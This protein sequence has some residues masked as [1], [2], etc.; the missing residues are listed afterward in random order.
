MDY[1]KKF[2]L[3]RR[4]HEFVLAQ[5]ERGYKNVTLY[6][7]ERELISIPN[8]NVLKKGFTF[9]DAELNEVNVKFSESPMSLNITVDGFHSPVNVNHPKNQIKT[10]TR[11][12]FVIAFLGLLGTIVEMGYYPPNTA[13]G[14]ITLLINLIIM[15]CYILAIVSTY[16]QKAWGY[17]FG[18]GGY[19]FNI[20]I[21]LLG[22]MLNAN[23]LS[24][25]M[26]LVK[27]II[28][29]VILS[30]IKTAISLSKHE[31]Y[32]NLVSDELIDV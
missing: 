22:T 21:T 13:A 18:F 20:V 32:K 5:W 15:T 30:Y 31:K 2:P 4:P 25:M 19:T 27:G 8:P 1:E 29:A 10:V 16:N 24:I 14:L 26:L 3:T 6:F 9:H 23:L 28:Y 12:F 7:K 17:Y 11:V